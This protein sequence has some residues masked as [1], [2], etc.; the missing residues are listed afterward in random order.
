VFIDVDEP[1][2]HAKRGKTKPRDVVLDDPA[3]DSLEA[4]RSRQRSY[5][6]TQGKKLTKKHHVFSLA[7]TKNKDLKQVRSFKT[8]FNNLLKACSFSD[9]SRGTSLAPY[10]LR[11]SYTT[12]R[13]ED[14]TNIYVLAKQMGT[15]VKMIE[16]YYGHVITREQRAEL[17]KTRDKSQSNSSDKSDVTE[18]MDAVIAALNKDKAKTV[19]DVVRQQVMKEWIAENG[20][21]P[22]PTALGDEEIF[23]GHVYIRMRDLGHGDL[24]EPPDDLP[25]S[26]PD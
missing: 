24:Y 21:E 25:D 16:D 11:H 10:S 18:K 15:S 26:F 20:R 7:D 1:Y 17:T 19:V 4:I 23:E 14:G 6:S 2:L 8:G 5:L 3:V 22:D 12:M 9:E 13:I